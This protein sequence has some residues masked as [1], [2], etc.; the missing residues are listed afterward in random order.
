[1]YLTCKVVSVGEG[2]MGLILCRAGD[3]DGPPL[4]N[5]HGR[6]WDGVPLPCPSQP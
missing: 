1:M 3:S 4:L 2:M 6:S 5:G